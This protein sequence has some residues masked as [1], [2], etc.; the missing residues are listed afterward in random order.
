MKNKGFCSPHFY[1]VSNKRGVFKRQV[2]RREALLR[3]KL[4]GFSKLNLSRLPFC[5]KNY[6]LA[7]IL[8]IRKVPS[9]S[10]EMVG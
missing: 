10:E 3:K 5:K 7:M 4:C 8:M 9:S 1:Y 2:V 6:I